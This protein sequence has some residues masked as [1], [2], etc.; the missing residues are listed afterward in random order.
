MPEWKRNIEFRC[1][2][3]GRV[4]VKEISQMTKMS[5]TCCGSA[6]NV[7]MTNETAHTHNSDTHR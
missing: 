1:V 4:I 3:C 2:K 5:I 7:E 6:H